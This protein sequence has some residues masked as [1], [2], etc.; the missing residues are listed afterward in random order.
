MHQHDHHRR[1]LLLLAPRLPAAVPLRQKQ[2]ASGQ[3]SRILQGHCCQLMR[4]LPHTSRARR[5]HYPA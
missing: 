2:L 5:L 1:L 3:L 4:P